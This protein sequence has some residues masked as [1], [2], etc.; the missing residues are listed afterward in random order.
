M[1]SARAGAAAKATL[2]RHQDSG[3]TAPAEKEEEVVVVEEGMCK[4]AQTAFQWATSS[5]GSHGPV[6]SDTPPPL[7]SLRGTQSAV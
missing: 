1:L 6:E 5:C 4:W 2:R 3:E 7:L